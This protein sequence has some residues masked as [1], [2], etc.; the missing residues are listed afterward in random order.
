LASFDAE[1]GTGLRKCFPN[2]LFDLYFSGGPYFF[3][4]ASHCD[5]SAKNYWGG[6]L[7][8]SFGFLD[9]VSLEMSTSYDSYYGKALQG[10]FSINVPFSAR[11]VA[12]YDWNGGYLRGL[13]KQPVRRNEVIILERIHHI[14]RSNF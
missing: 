6:R 3:A 5:C 10:C 13:A 14:W 4:D 8:L 1:L 2:A 9:Y 12:Q 11:G 7:S